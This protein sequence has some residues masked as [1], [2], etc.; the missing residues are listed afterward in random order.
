VTERDGWNRF[1]KKLDPSATDEMDVSV[2]ARQ[3]PDAE[4][5]PLPDLSVVQADDA[6]L[7]ALGGSDPKVADG[8]GDQELNA[9]LLAWRRDIDSEPLADLVDIDT[10]V[11]TVKTAAMAKRNGGKERKRRFLVPV[12]AAAAVLAIAFTGTGIAARDAQPGDTLWG[13]T[14]VLYADQARSTEAAVSVR[15]D[16]EAAQLALAQG[17]F[18]EARKALEEAQLAMARVGADD[19]LAELRAQ[20]LALSQQL[21]PVSDPQG[22]LPTTATQP[23]A[24]SQPGPGG[25]PQPTSPPGDTDPTGTSPDPGETSPD[26]STSPPDS[27]DSTTPPP[28]SSTETPT[29]GE[30]TEPG[31]SERS[32]SSG[33]EPQQVPEN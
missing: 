2:D 17:R 14:K 23:P 32:E 15:T 11:I 1:V 33:I 31:T 29:S 7:D 19:E 9:L 3:D 5:Q 21:A 16:L 28:S 8:L 18:G 25:Q 20:H 22:P 27:S 26:T 24:S 10:A 12:A 6:L 30:G 13:L 4:L